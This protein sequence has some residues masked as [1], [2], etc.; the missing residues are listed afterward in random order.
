MF[1][2]KFTKKGQITIPAKYRKL[3]GTEIV[4]ISYENGAVV[5]KPLKKLGGILQSYAIRNRTTEE[6]FQMEKEAIADGF[7]EREKDNS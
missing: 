7:T 2:G 3:L 4:E 1:V 6:I 5:I